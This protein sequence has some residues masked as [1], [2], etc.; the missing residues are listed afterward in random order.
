MSPSLKRTVNRGIDYLRL[1]DNTSTIILALL[2][3]V[4]G[5]FGAIGFR[6]LI[7][8]LQYLAIG[9][10]G[11]DVLETLTAL[12][13]WRLLLVPAVGGILVSALVHRLAREA[14]GHGVPEVM[15]AVALHGGRIRP[16]VVAVKSLVSALC[17]ATGGSVGREGPIVQIGSAIGS[18]AGQYL[19][20]PQDRL[21]VLVGCGAAAGIAATFNAPVAGVMFAIEIILGNYAITTLT[22]LIISSVIATVVCHAFPQY[23]GGNVRA[24]HIP[25][26]YELASIWEIP[27]FFL[28][29]AVAAVVALAFIVLLYRTEDLFD[30]IRAR[31]AVKG[32]LGGLL[33]GAFFLGMPLLVGHAHCWGIGYQSIEMALR[34]DLAL[35]VLVLLVVFKLLTT[36]LTIGAGGSGG[37]F[38]PSLFLGAMVGGAFGMT[39]RF[40]FPETIAINPG[41]YALVG[42]GA[43]VAGT[44]HATI[45][46]IL[47]IFELTGDYQIILPLMI[48]CVITNLIASRLK[49]D[50]IYTMKLSR[51]GVNL[52]QGLE[53]TIMEST[54]VRDLMFSDVPRVNTGA[55]LGKVLSKMLNDDVQELY[56]TDDEGRLQGIITLNDVK[57]VINEAELEEVLT[58]ADLMQTRFQCVTPESALLEGMNR[59]CASN[60]GELPVVQDRDSMRLVGLVTH[61]SIFLLYNREVLRQGTLGLKF[62]HASQNGG[63]SDYVEIAEDHCVTV[64]PVTRNMAG[65][66]LRE[67]DLRARFHVNVIS[68]KAHRYE[69]S[70]PDNEVPDPDQKLKA[71]DT[72][73]VVGRQNEI[74]RMRLELY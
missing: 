15:E 11:T 10:T 64:L 38:A 74:H 49:T 54:Q 40:F 5:G 41:A 73:V 34:G 55:L 39:L 45:T 23:T 53:A 12:P 42:M 13:F 61:R 65:R 58:A 43:V 68:I 7:A 48:S 27:S 6:L 24:F 2:I 30:S 69:H 67:L 31:P 22:P 66:T 19:R 35:H 71:T 20:I 63:R 28:L 52:H 37:I 72:L 9:K 16:R 32:L 36:S 62:V 17:I 8:G 47:I 21:R 70:T 59:F 51:R 44:T 1:G 4:L 18:V 50:S 25:F 56:V 14:K 60:L 29:G 57:A 3:G 33:L 46:A 26:E